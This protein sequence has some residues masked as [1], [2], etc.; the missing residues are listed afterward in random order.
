DDDGI[1]HV[2][3][4]VFCPTRGIEERSKR[5]RAPYDVWCRD[6][7]MIPIGG[8]VMDY[9]QI[10][11]YLRDSLADMG[12]VVEQVHYDRWKI[13]DFQA[14]CDRQSALTDAEF[15]PVGQGFK[16][17]GVR[18]DCLLNNMLESKIKHGGHPLLTMAA[19]N[20]I[21]V[22]DPAGSVK[23][24]KSKSTRRIDPLVGMVQAVYP[25]LDGEGDGQM[26]IELWIG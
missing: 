19:S 9:D 7:F 26:E 8:E 22:R 18:C 14:A 16:D 23:L 21:A 17:M 13:N 2:R 1:V 11:V 15:I 6:G 5:D 10:A 24:D 20:A 25:L 3:P 12:I 4:F